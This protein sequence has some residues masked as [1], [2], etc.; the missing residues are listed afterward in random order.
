MMIF[1]SFFKCYK[2]ILYTIMNFISCY[3]IS[4]GKKKRKYQID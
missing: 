3:K 1:I 2:Y 4:N